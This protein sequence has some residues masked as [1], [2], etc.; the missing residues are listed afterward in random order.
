MMIRGPSVLSLT[1]RKRCCSLARIY[2][3]LIPGIFALT[4][5]SHWGT[6]K[7]LF[8]SAKRYMKPNGDQAF[9]LY[10]L[11]V[12]FQ[13]SMSGLFSITKRTSGDME[14]LEDL[15]DY[16]IDE[17]FADELDIEDDGLELMPSHKREDELF[18]PT[19]GEKGPEIFWA[20]RG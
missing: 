16:D 9:F 18:S 10:V 7:G 1:V 2:R 15:E 11:K 19:K 8:G 17:H 5:K 13:S 6:P 3:C 12:L 20:T 14:D 4:K